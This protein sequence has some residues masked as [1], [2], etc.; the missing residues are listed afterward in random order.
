MLEV[1]ETERL[2]FRPYEL[3]DAPRAQKLGND[4]DIAQTTF[5]SYP[6]T[7]E[8]AENWIK[9]HSNLIENGE[10][11]PFAVVLKSEQQLIGTMTIRVD[12]NHNKGELA[13]WIGKAYWGKGYATEASKKI[14][15]FGFEELKLNRIW[16]PVMTKN[17]AS[18]KVMQ[19]SGLRYEGTLNQDILRWDKFE[20]VGC[21]WS[22][23]K[24]LYVI[25]L[26]GGVPIRRQE[27]IFH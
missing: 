24:R 4:K 3:S 18:G 12:K 17:K 5:L 14:V 1:L 26:K 22:F 6:Y 7:L 27:R 19:K 10:A 20:D 16:A 8:I 2:L 9:G 23:K 13:Y 25:K 21:I 15:E 11:Y